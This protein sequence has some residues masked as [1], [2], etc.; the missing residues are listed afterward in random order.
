MQD[1]IAAPERSPAE[2]RADRLAAL[3]ALGE[4]KGYFE[5]LGERHWAL[6]VDEGPNLLVSFTTLED[7]PA[8]DGDE[9]PACRRVS[10][11]S[12]WSQLCLIADGDTWYRDPRVYRFFDRLIDEG[13]FEDFDRVTFFGAGMGGYAA[14][15]FSVAAPGASVLAIRPVATLDPSI[16]GW[17]KRHLAAR[18]LDFRSRFG[19]GPDMIEGAAH[20]TVIHDPEVD[21]DAMHAALYHKRFV[22]RL[23]CRHLGPMPEAALAE[24]GLLEPLLAAAGE[25]RLTPALW[26]RLWR[27]RRG[28]PNWLRNMLVRLIEQPN[29]L[30]EG[31]FLRAAL[32]QPA[33]N[34]RMRKRM[35]E[36]QAI[37]ARN[38]QT[39]PDPL[40][41]A[42]PG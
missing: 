17:D 39:L 42:G 11:A 41:R 35:D 4:D 33:G 37:L 26:A 6:F 8:L 14:C 28:N 31:I 38:G 20:V 3:D 15:A 23:A 12:G 24:M 19:Y 21:E 22:T 25:G 29:R 36:L 18:R 7:I 40:G 13:F 9:M 16:A 34:R 30:R 5:P 10:M 1:D 27:A 32:R 2:R